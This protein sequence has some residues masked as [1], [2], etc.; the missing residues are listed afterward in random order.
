MSEKIS[1]VVI[2]CG[3]AGK[4]HAQAYAQHTAVILRA[5]CDPDIEQA[6]RLA[7]RFGC[8]AYSTVEEMLT[9]E[10]PDIASIA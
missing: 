8:K 9:I 7:S 10:K 5:V 4:I 3:W 1:A 6:A 2:G